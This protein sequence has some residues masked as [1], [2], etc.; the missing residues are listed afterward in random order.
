MEELKKQI[1]NNDLIKNLN[2]VTIDNIIEILV[3]MKFTEK[4][5]KNRILMTKQI[6]Q[7]FN[8]VEIEKLNNK[9]KNKLL[10]TLIYYKTIIKELN[11]E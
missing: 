7:K 11:E 9:L 5:Q 10:E 3:D 4:I 1:L 2:L 8:T 6:L